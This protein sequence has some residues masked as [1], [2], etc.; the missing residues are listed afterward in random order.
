MTRESTYALWRRGC[1]LLE[2]DHN[3]QAVIV[4]ER[5]LALEPGKASIR[6]A[7]ARAYYAAGRPD[8]ARQE[9]EAALEIDPANDYA[10]FGLALC[11]ERAGELSS[12]RGHAKL[13]V[14]MRPEDENYR[15]ALER[16]DPAS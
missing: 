16:I 9:F 5:A 7:L 8:A 12:A 11:L 15:R 6:E 10:H 4:L 2:Q 13:A 3:H 1:A 14:V